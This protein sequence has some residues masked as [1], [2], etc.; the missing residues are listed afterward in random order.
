MASCG[1]GVTPAPDR[2][3]FGCERPT[4]DRALIRYLDFTL[5]ANRHCNWPSGRRRARPHGDRSVNVL[6]ELL[7]PQFF[8]LILPE[9][10]AFWGHGLRA[11]V[12]GIP[13]IIHAVWRDKKR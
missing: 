1:C 4:A 13:I 3:Q 9:S 12:I 10:Y 6:H 11:V 8:R 7:D 2:S 5:Y